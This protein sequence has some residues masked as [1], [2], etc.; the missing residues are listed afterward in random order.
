MLIGY[1][2]QSILSKINYFEA[3][4]VISHIYLQAAQSLTKGIQKAMPQPFG[5]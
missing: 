1:A 5:R 2:M 4:Y 3:N